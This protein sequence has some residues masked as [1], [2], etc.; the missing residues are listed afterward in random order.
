MSQPLTL[1]L[2]QSPFCSTSILHER[3]AWLSSHIHS[4]LCVCGG[5]GEGQ[6]PSDAVGISSESGS[7]ADTT[8]E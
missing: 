3:K 2:W 4:T 8:G 6:K 7:E 5:E 1:S